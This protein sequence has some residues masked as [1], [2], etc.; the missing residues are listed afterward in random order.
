MALAIEAENISKTFGRLVVLRKIDLHVQ[1]GE[2]VALLGRNGAGKTTLLRVISSLV[3]PTTG[4]VRINGQSASEFP[5][6]CR[7]QIGFIS[8]QTFLYDDLTP[9]QN[10]S[11]YANLY[12]LQHY[13]ERI[14]VLLERLDLTRWRETPVR[15]FS[16]GMKQRLA[17]ARAFLHDPSLLF[18]D[19]PFTG[20]DQSA[21]HLL[22]G[23][24]EQFITDTRAMILVTHNLEKSLKLASR[25]VI[26]EKGLIAFDQPTT[27]L[28]LSDLQSVYDQYVR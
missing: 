25:I 17:I 3:R 5:E 16:R 28:S 19:E 10:L 13:R 26:I 18:L 24:I 11:F 12:G 23:L 15:T 20:L 22:I 27:G 1:P 21:S 4:T 14:N 2:R 7:S 6:Q 9:D 8:H